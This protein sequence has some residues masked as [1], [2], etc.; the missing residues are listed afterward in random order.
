MFVPVFLF[1][2][3]LNIYDYKVDSA[4]LSAAWSGLYLLLARRRKQAFVSKWGPRGIIR[5]TTMGLC[6]AQLVSGGM[7][8]AVGRRDKEEHEAG[9]KPV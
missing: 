4:G 8:Y 9:G 7:V 6:V 1:S 3:Y 2:S 5:G